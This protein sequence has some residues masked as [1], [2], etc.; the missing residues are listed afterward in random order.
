M[1]LA[2]AVVVAVEPIDSEP[3]EK[4]FPPENSQLIAPLAAWAVAGVVI[5]GNNNPVKIINIMM[6]MGILFATTIIIAIGQGK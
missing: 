1:Y 4:L 3:N 6:R 2:L 5:I